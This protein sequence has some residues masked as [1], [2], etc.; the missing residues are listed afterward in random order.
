MGDGEQMLGAPSGMFSCWL[1][2]HRTRWVGSNLVISD[3][4]AACSSIPAL[5]DPPGQAFW[6][7]WVVPKK[8]KIAQGHSTAVAAGVDAT[9]L[10]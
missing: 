10:P 8:C 6:L 9:H 5:L 1:E 2:M 4:L 7:C 3:A